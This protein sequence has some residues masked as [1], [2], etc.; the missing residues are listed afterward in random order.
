MIMRSQG[1][2]GP[3]CLDGWLGVPHLQGAGYTGVGWAGPPG[4]YYD[5]VSVSAVQPPGGRGRRDPLLS[6]SIPAPRRRGRPG[7]AE[8]RGAALTFTWK[9]P[10]VHTSAQHGE[11]PSEWKPAGRRKDAG[12]FS[13]VAFPHFRKEGRGWTAGMSYRAAAVSPGVRSTCWW[14]GWTGRVLRGPF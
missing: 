12:T 1:K 10:L 9:T 3:E 8:S 5:R 11:K 2:Q 13:S 14:D 6:A 4:R 7:C